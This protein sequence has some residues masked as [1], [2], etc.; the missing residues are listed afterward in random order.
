ME[1]GGM[2]TTSMWPKRRSSPPTPYLISMAACTG[3]RRGGV[4]IRGMMLSG[5]MLSGM[6]LSGMMLSGMMLRVPA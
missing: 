4:S 6:M 3:D 2:K 5:M 1:A